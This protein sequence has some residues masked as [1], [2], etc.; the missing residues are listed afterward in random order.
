MLQEPRTIR[1]Y[2]QLTDALVDLWNRGYR[3]D[4][5]RMYIDGYLA[6]LKHTRELEIYLIHR[7]EEDAIRYIRDP[8]NFEEM[9][10]PQTE[11]D[12]YRL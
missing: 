1:H 7:L 4:D 12:Y 2:Q 8:S 10:M 6:A 9:L 11:S 5:L 3:F